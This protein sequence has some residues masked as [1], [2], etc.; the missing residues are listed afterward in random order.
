MSQCDRPSDLEVENA[1]HQLELKWAKAL[2]YIKKGVA[3]PTLET[4]N[5]WLGRT[6][7]GGS[8]VCDNLA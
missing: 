7:E 6:R 5:N 2:I 1:L 4:N 3:T 8:R